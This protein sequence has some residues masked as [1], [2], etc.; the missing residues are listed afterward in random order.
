MAANTAADTVQ[1]DDLGD[2]A[3]DRTSA[4]KFSGYVCA[5]Q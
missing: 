1:D 3:L 2:E 5:V 4:G